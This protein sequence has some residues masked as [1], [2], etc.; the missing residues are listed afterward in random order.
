MY[1]LRI[2]NPIVSS[3]R[4]NFVMPLTW[5][6]EGLG[7]EA[8]DF[9]SKQKSFILIVIA[10]LSDPF[11]YSSALILLKP[12]DA[13][14][15]LGKIV[16]NTFYSLNGCFNS[17]LLTENLNYTFF[18]DSSF[19]L[20]NFRY[21]HF[22]GSRL[23]SDVTLSGSRGTIRSVNLWQCLRALVIQNI[24]AFRDTLEPVTPVTQRFNDYDFESFS[25][26][27][28]VQTCLTELPIYHMDSFASL[29][30]CAMCTTGL[31]QR[32]HISLMLANGSLAPSKYSS[33][34][35]S[36]EGLTAI[37]CSKKPK[38]PKFGSA[39]GDQIWNNYLFDM[40]AMWM[41]ARR[42]H[43]AVT[44]DISEEHSGISDSF[45]RDLVH[46]AGKARLWSL[47]TGLSGSSNMLSKT[48]KHHSLDTSTI[49]RI[50]KC[51][52]VLHWLYL[53]IWSHLLPA[54]VE[55]GYGGP[56]G[57]KRAVSR[58]SSQV[59]VKSDE[60]LKP[61]VP[62]CGTATLVDNSWSHTMLGPEH[63]GLVGLN[64]QMLFGTR[65][66]DLNHSFYVGFV[67]VAVTQS[68]QHLWV[69]VRHPQSWIGQID[70]GLPPEAAYTLVSDWADGS[71]W[72]Y[73]LEDLDDEYTFFR[74]SHWRNHADEQQKDIDN[75]M[76]KI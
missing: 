55:S 51:A 36:V 22:A 58:L 70:H 63:L 3:K 25:S 46:A 6:R 69:S 33:F 4:I 73:T 28:E 18:E 31:L 54:L 7:P 17:R 5:P 29:L 1:D 66:Q 19:K 72:S 39:K 56:I 47:T 65:P 11:W 43:E 10:L 24:R 64:G 35:R 14:V 16:L 74:K 40:A 34:T 27:T 38:V 48:L 67:S 9:M 57:L 13:A 32:L 68:T 71:P 52:N 37:F 23:D 76:S 8:I 30:R 53:R 62:D 60:S 45:K 44:P 12:F 50:T 15:V 75:I 42:F 20:N 61:D 26:I 41:V 49:D 2:L 59:F 21:E